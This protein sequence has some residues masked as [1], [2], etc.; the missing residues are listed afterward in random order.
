[1]ISKFP[2]YEV[3]F[4]GIGKGPDGSE[5]LGCCSQMAVFHRQ[6]E[7]RVLLDGVNG[8]FALVAEIKYPMRIDN[9]SD[10]EKISDDVLYHTRNF[11][12]DNNGDVE[13]VPL[14]KI[15][16]ALESLSIST[17]NLREILTSRGYVIEEREE[18]SVV[19]Q[20]EPPDSSPFS[21]DD[22][23]PNLQDIGVDSDFEEDWM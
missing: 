19:L 13:F 18:G 12:Y 15:L 5:E 22:F 1:M 3:T 17:E 9:R 10:E 16:E 11:F 6:S 20:E 21:D 8:L 14:A 2:D 23:Y 7:D 4:E